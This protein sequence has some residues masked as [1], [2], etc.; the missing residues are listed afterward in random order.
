M[1]PPSVLIRPRVFVDGNQFCAL[2]G[3]NIQEGICGFGDTP[4]EALMAF[5]EEWFKGFEAVELCKS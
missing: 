4:E 2:Y 3:E 1:Q 5:D